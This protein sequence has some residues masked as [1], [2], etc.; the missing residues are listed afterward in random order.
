ML[1]STKMKL[2][3]KTELSSVTMLTQLKTVETIVKRRLV[4]SEICASVVA[5]DTLR[6]Y[7]NPDEPLTD[8]YLEYLASSSVYLH[9]VQTFIGCSQEQ[10]GSVL[11]SSPSPTTALC[12]NK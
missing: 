5:M 10:V 4:F 6:H 9:A 7:W 1:H 8:A 12:C 11:P 2:S 3:F